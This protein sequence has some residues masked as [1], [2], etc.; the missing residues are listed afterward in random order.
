MVLMAGAAS[1]G[2]SRCYDVQ[3]SRT[4]LARRS[5]ELADVS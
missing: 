5:G 4:R 1:A 2:R 3:I